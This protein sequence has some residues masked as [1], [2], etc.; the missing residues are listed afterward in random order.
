MYSGE[1]LRK[2]IPGSHGRLIR[3]L[4]YIAPQIC[5]NVGSRVPPLTDGH[6]RPCAKTSVTEKLPLLPQ[7]HSC[8]VP[9]GNPKRALNSQTTGWREQGRQG[10]EWHS[11]EA[12]ASGA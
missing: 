5:Q 11:G 7:G 6:R 8:L 12:A 2:L 10:L 3:L 9:D 4:D 1:R